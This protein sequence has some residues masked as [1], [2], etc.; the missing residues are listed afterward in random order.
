MKPDKQ[1]GWRYR[2]LYFSKDEEKFLSEMASA[3]SQ[4]LGISVPNGKI[5]KAIFRYGLQRLKTQGDKNKMAK[6]IINQIDRL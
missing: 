1:R 5:A 3:V 2:N 6:I 4:R